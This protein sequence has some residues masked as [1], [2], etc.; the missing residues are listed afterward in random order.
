MEL[1]ARA[2]TTT[3]LHVNRLSNPTAVAANFGPL[4]DPTDGRQIPRGFNL[5]D[6]DWNPVL[7]NPNSQKHGA[8]I[9]EDTVTDELLIVDNRQRN[10]A[11]DIYAIYATNV[12]SASSIEVGRV[13]TSNIFLPE[14]P[15]TGAVTDVGTTQVQKCA[16]RSPT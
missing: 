15:F 6:L 4:L 5:G 16:N 2:A 11:T 3:L 7:V 12:T 10:P 1:P 13:D 8:L 9:V 14:I